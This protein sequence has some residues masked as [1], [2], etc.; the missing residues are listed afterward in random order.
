AGCLPGPNRQGGGVVRQEGAPTRNGRQPGW[1]R[2]RTRHAASNEGMKQDMVGP[3]IGS[4]FT[5]LA[6]LRRQ[7]E[8]TSLDEFLERRES[9]R[10]LPGEAGR[11]DPATGFGGGLIDPVR[12]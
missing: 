11:S 10:L 5:P 3:I 1:S 9:D 6:S 2:S 7:D 12:V 4:G 8:T